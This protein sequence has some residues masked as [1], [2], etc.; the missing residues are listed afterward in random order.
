MMSLQILMALLLLTD[1]I[2]RDNTV[3]GFS[4]VTPSRI[5]DTK[6]AVEGKSTALVIRPPLPPQSTTSLLVDGVSL[7]NYMVRYCIDK[8]LLIC[9]KCIQTYT[10]LI[11]HPLTHTTHV[12]L[13]ALAS[14]AICLD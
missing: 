1:I 14:G 4:A 2:L 6:V 3:I 13:L 11:T 7:T 10:L 9:F 5:K 8:L 12:Y